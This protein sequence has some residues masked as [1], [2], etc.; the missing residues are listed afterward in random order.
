MGAAWLLSG[1]LNLLPALVFYLLFGKGSAFYGDDA[2]F[3]MS[4]LALSCS[5]GMALAIYRLKAGAATRWRLFRT[6]FTS[7]ILT[8]AIAV[9]LFYGWAAVQAATEPSIDGYGPMDT[10]AILLSTAPP[11][12]LYCLVFLA[13]PA[14]IYGAVILML[15]GYGFRARR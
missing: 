6:V 7:A 5:F 4:V 3:E 8:T 2:V 14:A 12:F 9:S 10:V 1:P 13:L 11:V 15:V